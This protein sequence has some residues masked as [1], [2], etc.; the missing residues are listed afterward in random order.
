MPAHCRTSRSSR[1]PRA[2]HHPSRR[3]KTMYP[4]SIGARPAGDH[5]QRRGEV[6]HAVE[7]SRERRRTLYEAD[8]ER[9][10]APYPPP[11]DSRDP[12]SRYCPGHGRSRR[13]TP[14]R[15]GQRERS[16]EGERAG[17]L[18][19]PK[20]AGHVD[21]ALERHQ[22]ASRSPESSARDPIGQDGHQF[23]RR[24]GVVEEGTASRS[25]A[26][27]SR[28]GPLHRAV[29]APGGPGRRQRSARRRPPAEPRRAPRQTSALPC[30]RS[31]APPRRASSRWAPWHHPRPRAPRRV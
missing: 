17:R 27:T 24:T 16:R 28:Q 3:S 13:D 10:V 30:V 7:L 22:A 14:D 26:S 4:D 31:T 29:L 21:D 20:A 12:A 11:L 23:T 8:V 5:A 1:S 6:E 18:R 9:V 19:A 2:E 25:S 15:P